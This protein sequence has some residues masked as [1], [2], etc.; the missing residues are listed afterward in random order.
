MTK[1]KKMTLNQKLATIIYTIIGLFVI[2][3]LTPIMAVRT[4]LLMNGYFQSAF[5]ARIQRSSENA[6]APAYS[7]DD[8]GT[9]YYVKPSPV[10]QAELKQTTARLNRYAVKTFILSFAE[11]TWAD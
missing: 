9:V 10:S 8:E 2:G 1:L 3:H 5:C 6:Y 11:V 4:K 7:H